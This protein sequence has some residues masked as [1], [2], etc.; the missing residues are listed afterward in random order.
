MAGE[1]A[2]AIARRRRDKIARLQRSADLWGRGAAGEQATAK[3]LATLPSDSWVVLHDVRWPGRPFA[4]I[5]HVAIGPTGVFVIDS[6]SWSGSVQLDYGVLR[7]N[8]RPR[9]RELVSAWESAAAV[10][11][12]LVFL[13]SARVVP[14]LC[15]VGSNVTGWAE[16][17]IVSDTPNV[18]HALTSRRPVMSPDQV[19]A[20]AN[21]L[22]WRLQN[23]PEPRRTAG[24]TWARTAPRQ[25]Q[26][27]REPVRRASGRVSFTAALIGAVLIGTGAYTPQVATGLADFFVQTVAYESG[28]APNDRPA[29][30]KNKGDG[31][32]KT[33][34]IRSERQDQR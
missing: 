12:Q 22:R 8:G 24:T 6:R 17:V 9:G 31:A 3:A 27:R 28:K 10:A 26:P 25:V 32:E 15:L 18:V 5:D 23:A 34:Q 16:S 1:F 33:R 13:P 19:R 29:V 2:G 14:V 21:E 4:N 11:R 20:V 30:R 7:Q